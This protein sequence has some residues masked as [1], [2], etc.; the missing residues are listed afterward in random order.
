[1][2]IYDRKIRALPE[3]IRALEECDG[4]GDKC[5]DCAYNEVGD[6]CGNVMEMDAL[7]WLKE[8]RTDN[9]RL[10]ERLGILR[11]ELAEERER[12]ARW[13]RESEP[14]VH[15]HWIYFRGLNGFKQC[16]CSEC[17]TSYGCLDTPRCPNC[18]AHMDENLEI[19]TCYCPICDK[20]FEVRSN[21]SMGDCPDCG[22][23]VVL[24]E[25]EVADA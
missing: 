14:V 3:L 16:K 5:A 18:G 22:H 17:L 2:E 12:S 24:H 9:K 6:G 15:A 10:M 1:M 13:V 4:G 20:H 8:L 11:A 25:V 7:F 23:H 19:R 21:D